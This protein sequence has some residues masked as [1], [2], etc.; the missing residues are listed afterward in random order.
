M[1][2]YE[3]SKAA[4]Q[5]FENIF[6]FG[7]DRF[8]L[9]QAMDYQNGLKKQF[10]QLAEHPVLYPTFNHILQGYRRSVYRSHSIYY[11]VEPNRVFIVRILGQQDVSKALSD[12]E[13]PEQKL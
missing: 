4:D 13:I 6:D 3:L 10:D 2:H 8:G 5:D 11:K 12:E 1:A 9:S 7:I